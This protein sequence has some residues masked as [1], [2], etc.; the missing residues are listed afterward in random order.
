MAAI[1]DQTYKLNDV[2]IDKKTAKAAFLHNCEEIWSFLR[3][4]QEMTLIL[5]I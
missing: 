4:K 5:V 2:Y 3:T 1:T